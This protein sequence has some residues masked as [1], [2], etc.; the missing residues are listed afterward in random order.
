MSAEANAHSVPC[1]A[2]FTPTVA[3]HDG[4]VHLVVRRQWGG[5]L[6][7]IR[8]L[9]AGRIGLWH[10][11]QHFDPQRG[12]AF[13][14]YACPAIARQ[15]W[16]E[17]AQAKPPPQEI[18]TPAP[19]L[20]SPDLD[21]GIERAEAYA[22]LHDLVGQL[23]SPLR[24]VVCLYYGLAGHPPRSLRQLAPLLGLSHE[25]VRQRLLFALVR[26]RHP[27]NSLP[28]RQ[29]LGCDTVADYQR[30]DAQD[31]RQLCRRGGRREG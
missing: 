18:L 16:D 15:V 27:A 24:Q 13:S 21:E 6:P 17:V 19:P 1:A 4:L 11:L 25:M 14:S 23:P 22:L 28:L 2:S 3:A 7:Y 26:L 29:L 8:R 9:Q 10:A 5:N 20:P 12:T 31:L 30:A